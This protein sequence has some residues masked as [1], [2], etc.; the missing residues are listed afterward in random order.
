MLDD[1]DDQTFFE[2]A[3]INKNNSALVTD[4]HVRMGEVN[5][6]QFFLIREDADKFIQEGV[7]YDKIYKNQ[8][9]GNRFYG[10]MHGPRFGFLSESLQGSLVEYLYAC[11]L[12]PE[13]GLCVEYL[14]WNKE[15]RLYMAWLKSLYGHLFIQNNNNNMWANTSKLHSDSASV[16]RLEKKKEDVKPQP[17][18]LN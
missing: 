5:F 10:Q 9:G 7:W 2:V 14:S 6:S 11:G 18:P 16:N 13:I 15:Q 8:K 17:F 12:R 4:C 3:L 1:P